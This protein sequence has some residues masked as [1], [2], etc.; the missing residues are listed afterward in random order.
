MVSVALDEDAAGDD[1]AD[2]EQAATP[3]PNSAR[4]QSTAAVFVL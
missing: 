1:V 2:D 4:A 3:V